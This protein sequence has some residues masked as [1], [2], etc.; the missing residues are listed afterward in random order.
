[1]INKHDIEDFQSEECIQ[2]SDTPKH[3]ETGQ[4]DTADLRGAPIPP[5]S[6]HSS[7]KVDPSAQWIITRLQHALAVYEDV[8]QLIGGCADRFCVITGRRTGM[9][10]N[11]GCRCGTRLSAVTKLAFKTEDF[12]AAVEQVIKDFGA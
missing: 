12:R 1:M 2:T 8:R 9:V 4:P 7:N 6:G 3:G 5:C 11:G 10:T